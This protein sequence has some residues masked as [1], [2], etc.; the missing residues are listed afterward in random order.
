V[1]DHLLPLS[2]AFDPDTQ[3]VVG[4]LVAGLDDQ[5][6]RLVEAIRGLP[7]AAFEW[8]A[9][10]GTNS[11]GMLVAHLALVDVWWI[12][13]AP[14]GEG[15]FAEMDGHFRRVLGIVG[16]DDGMDVGGTTSFPPA[17]RGW[18]A[19]RYVALLEKA[20]DC[21]AADLAR[22]TDA[23]LATVVTGKRGS[24]THRWILYHVLEHFAAHVGQI[25]LVKHQLRD[26]GVLPAA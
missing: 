2:H 19:E 10:P 8:Q 22:W 21:V 20:R 3:A 14:R 12:H 23:S 7:V 17:L 13:L 5:R 6:R 1:P 26:A 16:R 24:V 9:A 4:T 18:T 15:V 25:L 11:I